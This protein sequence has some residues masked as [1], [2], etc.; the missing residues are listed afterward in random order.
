MNIDSL[1]L[2]EVCRDEKWKYFSGFS[3]IHSYHLLYNIHVCC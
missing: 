2:I 1:F 3:V